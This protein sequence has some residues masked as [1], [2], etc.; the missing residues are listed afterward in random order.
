MDDLDNMQTL[1]LSNNHN[2]KTYQRRGSNLLN[3]ND[4]NNWTK[5]EI[6]QLEIE[7][8][9]ELRRLSLTSINNNNTN[10]NNNNNNNNNMPT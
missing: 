2:N 8:L 7:M 5:T 3:P 6:D 4:A 1:N 10:N 9:R